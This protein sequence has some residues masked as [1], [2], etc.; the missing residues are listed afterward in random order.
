MP[1]LTIGYHKEENGELLQSV[2]NDP[3]F[4]VSMV[5]DVPGVEICGAIKNTVALGAGFVDGL[6]H[7]DN[8]KAA[9]IRIGLMEMKRFIQEYFP[10]AKDSTFFES[11]GVADLIVTCYGGRNRKCAEAFVKAG[12]SKTFTDIE[13]ELLNGQKV[14]GVGTC[15]EVMK[16]IKKAGNERQYPLITSI[17]KIC[18]EGAAPDSLLASLGASQKNIGM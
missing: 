5:N 17:H 9:V 8:S 2:F 12:G 16:I 13:K 14:Q 4:Q 15:E 18:F 3:C 1:Y 10:K 6:G 7:G 11:C